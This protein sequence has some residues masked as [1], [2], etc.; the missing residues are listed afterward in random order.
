[1]PG[2]IAGTV[3]DT[4]SPLL[5]GVRSPYVPVLV[6]GDRI[7]EAPRDLQAQ[8]VVLR[9]YPVESLRL[10][11]YLWPEVPARLAETPYL[12]TEAV[13]A[14]RIIGFTGEPVFRDMWRGLLPIYANAVLLGASF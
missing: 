4:L 3:G 10:A 7:Y 5:A 14:G 1:M 12:F 2:G 6:Q 9:Y 13:G 8:Q 11:G